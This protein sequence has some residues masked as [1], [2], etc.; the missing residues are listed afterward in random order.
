[1][2]KISLIMS[3]FNEQN[4]VGKVL[5][6]VK[7]LDFI[8]EIVL[9]DNG[10]TDD[11][12]S[13]LLE[14]KKYDDRINIFRIKKNRGLGLG[15]KLAIENTKGD[16]IVRQDADLE[17]DPDELINLVEIIEEEHADVVYG[18]RILVRKA[19]RVHYFYSYLANKIITFI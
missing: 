18:S 9:V 2:K 11:T 16:I 4:T 19:H 17:Y 14:A 5:A 6:K 15:I 1:M 3:A 13:K 12:Y 8:N 10:S 7:Y